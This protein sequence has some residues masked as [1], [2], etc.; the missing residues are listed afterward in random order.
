[1]GEEW[2]GELRLHPSAWLHFLWT[3]HY[4]RAHSPSPQRQALLVFTAAH[5]NMTQPK[6]DKGIVQFSIDITPDLTVPNFIP[7]EMFFSLMELSSLLNFLF[8]G[9]Q[10]RIKTQAP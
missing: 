2:A 3:L 1:M 9:L 7:C 4:C 10:F 8:L 5:D 6:N